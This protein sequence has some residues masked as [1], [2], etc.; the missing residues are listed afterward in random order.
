MPLRA[1]EILPKMR[2]LVVGDVM[3]DRYW[4]CEVDRISPEAPVPVGRVRRQ[5]DR[6]GGA[7]NAAAAVAALGAQAVLLGIAGRDEAGESLIQAMAAMPGLQSRLVFHPQAR[8]TVKLRALSRSQQMIRLD[9]EERAPPEALFLLDEVFGEEIEEADA[10]IFSDY[11]KGSLE[12]AQKLIAFAKER[13]KPV[14][15]DPKGK[16]F[17]RYRGASV[18]TP[19]KKEFQEAAGPWRDEAELQDKALSLARELELEALVLT[20]SE[21]GVSAYGAGDPLHIPAQA[22]E[23]FDISGAG[24]T[25]VAVLATLATAGMPFAEAL[26]WAN[27]AAGIA[28]AKVGTAAVPLAEILGESP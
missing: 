21:E 1:P 5:E 8:T 19:N 9:F 15:V 2:L 25:L 10:V 16:D 14:F 27:R 11:A 6:P 13:Q 28:V 24:D 22:R 20:R 18:L 26:F 12:H 7:A 4:F 17:C 23:V 3:L